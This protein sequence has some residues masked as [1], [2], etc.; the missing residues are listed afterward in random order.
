MAAVIRTVEP[1]EFA[2]LMA[3]IERSFRMGRDSFQRM[4]PHLYRPTPEACSWAYVAEEDGRF[5]AHVGLYPIEIV[6]AGV[7]LRVGGIGA[8]STLPEARGQGHMGRLLQHVIGEMRRLDYP[9][10]WLGGDRQRYNSYGWEIAGET[11]VLKFSQRS[12]EWCGAPRLPLTEVRPWEALETMTRYSTQPTYHV[13]R[14]DL[15]LQL[16]KEGLRAWV[17]DAGYVLGHSMDCDSDA[18]HLIELVAAEGQEI[19]LLHGLFEWVA[20]DSLAWELCA[21]DERLARLIP[22]CSEWWQRPNAQYRINDLTALLTAATATA[23]LA[24]RAAAL[25]DGA[26]TLGLRE[27]DRLTETTLTLEGGVLHVEAGRAASQDAAQY[28]ELDSLEAARVVLGGAPGGANR[29]PQE[30]RALFPVPVFVPPL[31]HV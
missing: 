6:T 13:R 9:L 12:L 22:Y 27:R 4:Y 7:P 28:V 8:V 29:L 18:V 15:E 19:A 21:W 31:D 5:L 1:S 24:G 30:W 26:L 16:H 10:S 11:A 2:S 23:A 17:S 14:P 3:L 20:Q 25:R